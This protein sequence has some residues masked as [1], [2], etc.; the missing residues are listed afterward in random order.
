MN[1]AQESGLRRPPS[2]VDGNVGGDAAAAGPAT[3]GRLTRMLVAVARLQW[4]YALVALVWLSGIFTHGLP[5]EPCAEWIALP[6]QLIALAAVGLRLASGPREPWMLWLGLFIACNLIANL[7]WNLTVD[8]GSETLP[9]I[10]DIVYLVNYGLLAVTAGAVYH[11]V[12]GPPPDR[13]LWLDAVTVL[14]A[15]LVVMWGLLLVRPVPH[16]LPRT[17]PI[18][19]AASYA[20]AIC[21]L[22]TGCVLLYVRTPVRRDYWWA[23]CITAAAVCQSLW[24]IAWLSSWLTNVDLV[25]TYYDYGDV[26]SMALVTS[27]LALRPGEQPVLARRERLN[28]NATAFV[29]ALAGLLAVTLVASAATTTRTVASW[30]LIAL[31]I[32]CAALVTLR[33]YR[34]LGE[35]AAAQLELALRRADERLT[36]LVRS[37]GDLIML[38]DREGVITFASPAA[39]R[40]LQ[41]PAAVLVG[42]SVAAVFGAAPRPAVAALLESLIASRGPEPQ[43]IEVAALVPDSG[44]RVLKITGANQL[45]NPNLDGLTVFVTDVTEQRDL[46]RHAL[47]LLTQ[48]RVRL[49][50]NIHDGLG[51]ELTGIAMMLQSAATAPAGADTERQRGQLA[52]II[53][54]LNG[55]I[56]T[57][58]ALAHGLSPLE[59]VRGSLG[60]ALRT[61]ADTAHGEVPV[62][63][64]VEPSLEDSVLGDF[65]ADHLCRI[66]TEA[67]HNAV[68]H[69]RC[70]RIELV[71]ATVGS[72]L[73]L[74][75]RDDGSGLPHG[76]E[77]RKEQGLGI[78]LMHYRARM[79][80][81][82]CVIAAAA[83]GGTRIEVR[84]PLAAVRRGADG[85]VGHAGAPRRRVGDG[86]AA[87]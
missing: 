25:G 65:P 37:A 42:E 55:S 83:G 67:V 13:R 56:R 81:G 21:V 74:S 3:R 73:V 54:R 71:L 59:V 24:E 5:P 35:L 45:G 62:S 60:N 15:L 76:A 64:E 69:S 53:E 72:D 33:N 40:I 38:V 29:P 22:L 18:A 78:R 14:S 32:L 36:E 17:L 43:S 34:A 51:Q 79:I 49:A 63:V 68:R 86:R 66:A 77:R 20:V 82:R 19:V 70:T 50:A 26:L 84:V 31:L 1:S 27:A 9:D 12:G 4:L 2:G 52:R 11:A 44:T 87:S 28:R 58:R 39:E 8:N 23:H 46:E 85:Q 80:G 16:E 10:T 61:L 41:R 48:E 7:A 47:D 75:I 30:T 6:L 57:A